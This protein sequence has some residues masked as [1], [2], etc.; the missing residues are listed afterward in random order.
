MYAKTL[1][2]PTRPQEIDDLIKRYTRLKA[3]HFFK[4]AK[5]KSDEQVEPINNSTVNR[6]DKLIDNPKFRWSATNVGK[7]DYKVLMK[8]SSVAM[9]S[10]IIDRYKELNKAKSRLFNE[11][12]DRKKKEYFVDKYIR[13]ELLKVNSDIE[14]I[15]DILVKY[16]YETKAQNKS[17]LWNSFGDVIIQN[18]KNNIPKNTKLCEVCGKRF[19]YNVSA[20]KPTIYCSSCARV[21]KLK[22]DKIRIKKNRENKSKFEHTQV[23]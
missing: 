18:I 12:R 13:N 23:Q 10:V 16:L 8:N 9:D 20:C 6:F 1:F 21:I 15:T 17:T 19:E 14:Y 7:F 11:E 3:P 5:D 4:Y 2:K 22:K